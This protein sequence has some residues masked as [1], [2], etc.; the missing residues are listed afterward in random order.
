MLCISFCAFYSC[1]A[2][3]ITLNLIYY[4]TRVQFLNQWTK[5]EP[6]FF[7]QAVCKRATKEVIDALQETVISNVQKLV[8]EIATVI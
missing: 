4:T 7:A 8:K 3:E 6:S 5:H 2:C 1:C